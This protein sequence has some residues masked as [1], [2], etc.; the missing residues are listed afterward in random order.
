MK[1][2]MCGRPSCCPTVELLPDGVT[3]ELEDD[4]GDT[5]HMTK[6]QWEDLRKAEIKEL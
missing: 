2:S 6:A 3:I 5:V 1:I 4:D